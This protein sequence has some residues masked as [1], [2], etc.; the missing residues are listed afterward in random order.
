MAIIINHTAVAQKLNQCRKQGEIK[1][2]TIVYDYQHGAID[3]GNIMQ[4]PISVIA[5]VDKFS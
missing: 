2:P 3:E 5:D 4:H 1:N